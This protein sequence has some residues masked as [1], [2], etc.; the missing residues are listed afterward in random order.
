M[1]NGAWNTV[2]ERDRYEELLEI[3]KDALLDDDPQD[4]SDNKDGDELDDLL[5]LTLSIYWA[6]SMG[7]RPGVPKRNGTSECRKHEFVSNGPLEKSANSFEGY[8]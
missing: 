5:E 7:R 4:D 6:A 8:R 1:S 2:Q 3:C